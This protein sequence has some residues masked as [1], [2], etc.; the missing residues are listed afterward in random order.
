MYHELK[1]LSHYMV[2]LSAGILISIS[3]D[4]NQIMQTKKFISLN[5]Q[6][7]GRKK[8]LFTIAMI[9]AITARS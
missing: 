9:L 3:E 5:T 2:L 6:E 7:A 4:H 1:Q 8:L